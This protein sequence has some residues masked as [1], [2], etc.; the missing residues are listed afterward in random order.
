M[1]DDWDR[2]EEW[3]GSPA[4]AETRRRATELLADGWEIQTVMFRTGV[5]TFRRP[6]CAPVALAAGTADSMRGHLSLVRSRPRK[7]VRTSAL[8]DPTVR[9]Q[10]SAARST[11]ARALRRRDT[12]RVAQPLPRV[13]ATASRGDGQAAIAGW[14]QSTVGDERAPLVIHQSAPDVP[15]DVAVVAVLAL[16][17]FVASCLGQ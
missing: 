9:S 12:S 4:R 7:L 15:P 11:L 5:W 1:Q 17:A 8:G 2:L 14:S 16:E 3:I 10:Q 13:E 6:R